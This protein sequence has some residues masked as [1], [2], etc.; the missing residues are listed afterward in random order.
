MNANAYSWSYTPQDHPHETPADVMTIHLS[1]DRVIRFSRDN[2]GGDPA[3]ARKDFESY[4][5][6]LTNIQLQSIWR[7][8]WLHVEVRNARN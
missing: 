7:E 8:R 4:L 2:V 6:A 5:I 1:A 3:Q